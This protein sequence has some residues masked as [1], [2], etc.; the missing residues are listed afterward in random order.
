M[1]DGDRFR[2]EVISTMPL[3]ADCVEKLPRNARTDVGAFARRNSCSSD[4]NCLALERIFPKTGERSS[5]SNTETLA[6]PVVPEFF[7]TIG[8]QRSQAPVQLKPGFAPAR[9]CIGRSW[10]HAAARERLTKS[11]LSACACRWRPEPHCR[12][13]KQCEHGCM[14]PDQ[15]RNDYGRNEERGAKVRWNVI[16]WA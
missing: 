5:L 7:N 4:T 3:R 10:D 11:Y 13:K 2:R 16:N 8:A 9:R 6:F 12:P 15:Q 14:G 1:G